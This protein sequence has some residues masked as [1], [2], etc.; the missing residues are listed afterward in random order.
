M[1]PSE[2]PLMPKVLIKSRDGVTTYHTY[3][4]H[5]LGGADINIAG[6][7]CTIGTGMA[8][9][10]TIL[11]EDSDGTLNA[12]V[13]NGVKVEIRASKASGDIDNTANKLLTGYVRDF[14]TLRQGTNTLGYL[15]TV[16]GSQVRFNERITNFFRFG[17]RDSFASENPASDTDMR[18]SALFTDLVEDTDHLPIG[19]PTLSSEGFTMTGIDTIV[20]QMP[21]IKEPF[22]EFTTVA[23]RLAE[24]GGLSWGVDATEDIFLRYPLL[25]HSGITIK[26]TVETTDDANTAYPVGAWDFRDSIQKT[27]GFANRLYGK[28]GTQL[29]VDQSQTTDSASTSLYDTDVAMQFTPTAHDLDAIRLIVSRTGTLSADIEGEVRLDV[30][31]TPTG[32]IVGTF[33]I[34]KNLVGT[35]A[36]QVT[37]NVES[38]GK[39]LQ[40]DKKH[41]I[42]LKENGDDASNHGNWH[43]DN[44]TSFTSATRSPGG[45]G[46]FTVDTT[47]F[48]YCFATLCSRR[49]LVEA[50]DGV[51]IANYGVVEAVIDAPWIIEPR[52]MDRYL[53]SVLSF[54]AKQKRIYNIPQ[55]K[56]PDALF[57]PGKLI[58]IMDT[59]AGLGIATQAELLKCRY[60]WD[61]NSN[62]MGTHYV[63]GLELVAHID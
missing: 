26:D 41:W 23:N 55:V 12:N 32:D 40:V 57:A 31:D 47:A 27:D 42:I 50:S 59:K 3:N 33:R 62:G 43:H 53:T 17:D 63:T 9:I 52:T 7:D 15:L 35:S 19:T 14:Q 28:G 61:A 38:H 51:S 60:V 16:Y 1:P 11:I 44:G 46:N 54:S 29:H 20:E 10:A 24:A 25:T 48:G 8:G 2:D 36:T 22:T 30:S 58:T 45:S 37:V 6:I 49:V 21:S 5:S 39:Y 56:A 18:I 13:K 4:A 34:W